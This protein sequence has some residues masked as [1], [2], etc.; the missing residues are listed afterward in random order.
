MKKIKVKGGYCTVNKNNSCN[1][2]KSIKKNYWCLS[3]RPFT[4]K[5]LFYDFECTQNTK[6]HEVNL[7][8]VHDYIGNEYI[9]N[10]IEDFCKNMINDEFK[11][12]TT[13]SLHITAKDTMLTLF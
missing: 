9:Y 2:N 10:N 6:I 8:I 1:I 13:H 11:G 5:Y 12:Y 3:C 7:A 4:E